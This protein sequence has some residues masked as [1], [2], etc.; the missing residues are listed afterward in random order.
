MEGIIQFYWYLFCR[1]YEVSRIAI[2]SKYRSFSRDVIAAM[3]E[4]DTKRFLIS[5]YW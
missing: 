4:D 3:L 1:F 5:F 2:P